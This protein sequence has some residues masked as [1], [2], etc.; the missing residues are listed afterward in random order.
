MMLIFQSDFPR[1]LSRTTMVTNMLTVLIEMMTVLTR[2]AMISLM[3]LHV[4]CCRGDC[5]ESSHNCR[6]G[7]CL[8]IG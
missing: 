7:H 8:S 5:F 1:L 3:A 6:I 4:T 2:M